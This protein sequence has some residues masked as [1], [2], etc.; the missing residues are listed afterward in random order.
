MSSVPLI[1]AKTNG[2]IWS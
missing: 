2:H 1:Q